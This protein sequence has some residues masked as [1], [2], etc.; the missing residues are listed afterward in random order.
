MTEEHPQEHRRVGR[1]YP[2]IAA[3]RA[4]QTTAERAADRMVA[5]HTRRGLWEAYGAIVDQLNAYVAAG[6]T[7]SPLQRLVLDSQLLALIHRIDS[8]D[9]EEVDHV[10]R[11]ICE[12]F[13][14]D[15]DEP[16]TAGREGGD[17]G[18]VER[19]RE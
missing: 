17:Y 5:E 14:P 6:V 16:C 4:R 8:I 15:P 10:L 11:D 18:N 3:V 7:P 12:A 9:R 1:A 19:G 13:D 2:R